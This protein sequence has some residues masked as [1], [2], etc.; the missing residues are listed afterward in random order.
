MVTCPECGHECDAMALGDVEQLDER[1][2][3]GELCPLGQCPKCQALIEVP[4]EDVP[5]YT[6]DICANIMRKRG[7]KV[8]VPHVS[9]MRMVTEPPLVQALW[10][11]I[12]NVSDEHPERSEMFFALR[13][14]YRSE[15]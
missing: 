11:F 3:P 15:A 13:A 6:L 2:S 8:T 5:N 1:V 14:R 10:W 7:W 12:E 4:D 9:E